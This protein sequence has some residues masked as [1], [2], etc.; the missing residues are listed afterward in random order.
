[1]VKTIK[2]SDKVHRR[3][4]LV[5]TLGD[6]FDTAIGGLLDEHSEWALFRTPRGMKVLAEARRKLNQSDNP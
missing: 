2:I 4:Q 1:M 3:L 5:G 6:T